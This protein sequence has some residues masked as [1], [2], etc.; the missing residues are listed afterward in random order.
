MEFIIFGLPFLPSTSLTVF[1]ELTLPKSP[2]HFV[3]MFLHFLSVCELQTYSAISSII[4][5]VR[6]RKFQMKKNI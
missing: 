1:L 4:K 6:V 3:T 2:L 5:V